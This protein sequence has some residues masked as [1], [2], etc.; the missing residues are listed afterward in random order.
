MD[1]QAIRERVAYDAHARPTQ[2][3]AVR[4]WLG[5]MS[6][7]YPLTLTLTIKQ[8]VEERNIRGCRSRALTRQDC[9][10]VA[11]RFMQ[12]LNRQVFGRYAAEKGGKSLLFIPVLEGERSNKNLH[13]HFAIG[14][15]PNHIKFNQF[16]SLVCEAKK[17]VSQIDR[18][19][20]V[21][22]ADSGWITYIT[23]EVGSRDSDAVLWHLV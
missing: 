17:Q 21:D 10:Q 6:A 3:E 15:L 1:L 23:K 11:K 12:K 9:E 18:E 19:H 5:S 4:C 8:A 2:R 14:G 16:E 7:Q 20:K 22:I 13:L